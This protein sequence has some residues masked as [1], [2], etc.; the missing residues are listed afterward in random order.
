[1][2]DLEFYADARDRAYSRPTTK[3]YTSLSAAT[4]AAEDLAPPATVA[5]VVA[6]DGT[7]VPSAYWPFADR[8]RD[9]DAVIEHD[10][11]RDGWAPFRPVTVNTDGAQQFD[12]SVVAGRGRVTGS[13]AGSSNMRRFYLRGG[14]RWPD[15]DIT[16][17]WW[18]PS[19]F[20]VIRPQM[21]HV[22]GARVGEDGRLRG[23]VVWFNI[24]GGPNPEALLANTW[25]G[26]LTSTLRQGTQ[27]P[28]FVAGGSAEAVGRSPLVV[29]ANRF[30]FGGTFLD[31]RVTPDWM[32]DGLVAGSVGDLTGMAATGLNGVDY[33]VQGGASGLI[34]LNASGPALTD[35]VAGGTWTPD[36]PGRVFPYN[37]RSQWRPPVLRFKQW[38]YGRPEPDWGGRFT[39]SVNLVLG[40]TATGVPDDGYA[41]LVAAHAHTGAYAEW[42]RTLFQRAAA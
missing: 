38:P 29:W 27:D 32:A 35:N 16:S 18:G 24:V 33:S 15:S 23:A 17:T 8:Q 6:D 41:G 36:Y 3:R 11:D 7:E 21:G 39:W 20:D 12:T 22:H 10:W 4:Q 13:V 37:V 26:T 1:M 40:G 14:T 34:R 19:T 5:R 30:V 9:D 28:V 42:G 31:L 25:E 2:P